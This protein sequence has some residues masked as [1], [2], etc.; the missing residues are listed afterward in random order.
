MQITRREIMDI[1]GT[2]AV[3]DILFVDAEKPFLDKRD[4][5][6]SHVLNEIARRRIADILCAE[7]EITK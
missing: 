1:I 3:H 2:M 7:Y 6:V 4:L 5:T